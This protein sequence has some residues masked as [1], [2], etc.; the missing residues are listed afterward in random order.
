MY[1]TLNV[2]S[3]SFLQ[4]SCLE[5]AVMTWPL[6]CQLSLRSLFLGGRA[7]HILPGRQQLAPA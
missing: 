5:K 7:S 6:V 1:H 3:L 2:S 4:N